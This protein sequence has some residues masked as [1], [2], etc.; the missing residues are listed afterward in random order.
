MQN[1]T[2][3]GNVARVNKVEGSNKVYIVVADHK[4]IKNTEGKYEQV[5][6]YINLEGFIPRNLNIEVGR[7]IGATFEIKSYKKKDG[8]YATANNIIY[9]DT[10]MYNKK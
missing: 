10:T 9:L 1:C 4:L 8:T 6:N 5:T 7:L 2:V 3:V